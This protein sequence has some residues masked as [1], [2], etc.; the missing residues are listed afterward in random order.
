MT[1]PFLQRIIDYVPLSIDHLFLYGLSERLQ[2]TLIEKL[3][4]GS[5]KS[6]ERCAAYLSED[7]GVVAARAELMSKKERLESV[8]K[9]LDNFMY[10]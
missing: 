3:G 6:T 2:D 9:E 8:Q 1:V 5:A 10:T 7:P 4:L